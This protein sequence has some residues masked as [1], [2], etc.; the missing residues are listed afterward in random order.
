MNETLEKYWLMLNGVVIIFGIAFLLL[1]LGYGRLSP[2]DPF[3]LSRANSYFLKQF[4]C[5]DK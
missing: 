4:S 2:I 5:Y 3:H 1:G